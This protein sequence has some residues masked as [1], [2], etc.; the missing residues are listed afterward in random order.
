MRAMEL[1]V[2]K[3]K[4]NVVSS[5]GAYNCNHIGRL[6]YYTSWAAKKDI[7]AMMFVNVGHPAVSV[8]G[9]FGRVFGTNPFSVSI[10]TNNARPFLLD[11]ATSMVAQGKVRIALMKHERVPENWIRD[12]YGGRSNDPAVLWDG[13]WLLPFGEYKGY[14]LQMLMELMGAVM[15]GSRSGLDPETEPPSTNGVFIIAVD[16]EGFVG[17]EAFK[18]RVEYVLR[19]VK[20]TTPMTGRKIIIPGEPEWETRERRLRNGIPVHR[21]TWVQIVKL[22]KELGVD[23]SRLV[24][25]DK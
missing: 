21:E 3:A 18:Q 7:V 17:L 19:G 15:T 14:C 1:A 5:V 25:R 24:M 11:Y 23:S 22:A 16:P 6:G 12:R 4:A 2:E 13:G 10:P 8:Y 9:G 20:N